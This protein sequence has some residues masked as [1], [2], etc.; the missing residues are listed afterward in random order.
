MPITGDAKK[1]MESMVDEYG[2]EKG[3]DVFYATAN[4]QH[5]SHRTWKK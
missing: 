4:K 2:P 5:R 3:K 1:V